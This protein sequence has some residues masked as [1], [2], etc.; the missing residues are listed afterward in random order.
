MGGGE[1]VV[2]FGTRSHET[3]EQTQMNPGGMTVGQHGL[4]VVVSG[5]SVQSLKVH[6]QMKPTGIGGQVGL[7]ATVVDV[8]VVE[9]VGI[10][11]NL[12]EIEVQTH[13]KPNGIIGGHCGLVVVVVAGVVVGIGTNLQDEDVQTHL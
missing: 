3:S 13:L 6:S 1:W 10:G 7:E 12:Q 2:G 8:V 11:T 5:T 4:G 9:E